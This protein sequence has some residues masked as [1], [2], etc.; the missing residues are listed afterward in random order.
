MKST[1]TIWLSVACLVATLLSCTDHRTSNPSPS[2]LRIKTVSSSSFTKTYSYDSQ[3]RLTTIDRSDGSLGLFVYGDPEMKYVR[4]EAD[5]NFTYYINYPVGTDRTR[6]T[7]N[8]LPLDLGS[9][10][11]TST[12]YNLFESKFFKSGNSENVLIS[13]SIDANKRIQSYFKRINS[14]NGQQADEFQY[15]GDNISFGRFT[16]AAGR[17]IQNVTFEY[18]GKSNPFFGLPDP[19]ILETRR[20]SRNNVTI[21][22][23][24]NFG[25]TNPITNYQ[26]E[27]NQQGLP[28]KITVKNNQG[29]D[30][31]GFYTYESY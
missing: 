14:G 17:F 21:S 19:D 9:S 8:Q 16:Q 12:T 27:Y 10:S 25:Y 11:F 31:V 20:Y 3:N 4:E 28:T 6:G 7:I 24:T 23:I 5:K 29:P 2:Q 13:Y 26:Y 1:F 18:D 30:E 15:T 22:T